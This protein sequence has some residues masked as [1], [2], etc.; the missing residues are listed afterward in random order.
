MATVE[1]AVTYVFGKANAKYWGFGFAYLVWLGTGTVFYKVVRKHKRSFYIFQAD[2]PMYGVLNC[3]VMCHMLVTL[4]S[5]WD[6]VS[7]I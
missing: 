2:I 6:M 5:I 1:S 4:N 3:I 7:E